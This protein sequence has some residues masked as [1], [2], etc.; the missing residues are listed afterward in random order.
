VIISVKSTLANP[1]VHYKISK[2][3]R[4]RGKYQ[5]NKSSNTLLQ[6]VKLENIEGKYSIF[7]PFDINKQRLFVIGISLIGKGCL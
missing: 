4:E 7:C 5:F 3:R 2:I 6:H 1:L